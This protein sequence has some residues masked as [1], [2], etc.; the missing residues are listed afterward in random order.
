MSRHNML[1]QNYCRVISIEAKVMLEMTKKQII[2]AVLKY[3]KEISET[4][5][6][7]KS[8]N[9]NLECYVEE[10]IVNNLSSLNFELY[11]EVKKLED[12]LNEAH[13][14]IDLPARSIFYR[15]SIISKMNKIRKISD[16]LEKNT[17]KEVWPFPSYSDILFSI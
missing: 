4:A 1:L 7:K 2:P 9:S 13:E 11:N 8:L 15:D 3:I 12:S 5:L 6:T 10:D 16:T 14:L 17:S